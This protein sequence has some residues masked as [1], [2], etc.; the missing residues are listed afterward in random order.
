VKL[1]AGTRSATR[2]T[3]SGRLSRL[4]SSQAIA[5]SDRGANDKAAASVIALHNKVDGTGCF[6]DMM[7][8]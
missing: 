5:A 2:I 3:V 7:D 8:L 4:R 6:I 1:P